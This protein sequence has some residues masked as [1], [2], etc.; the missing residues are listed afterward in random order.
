[1]SLK[2]ERGSETCPV[3]SGWKSTLWM[4]SV[5]NIKKIIIPTITQTQCSHPYQCTSFPNYHKLSGRLGQK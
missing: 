1:M 2:A 3:S 4:L 5:P